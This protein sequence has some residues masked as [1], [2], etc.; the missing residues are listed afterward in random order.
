ML[1]SFYV[2]YRVLYVEWPAAGMRET[3]LTGLSRKASYLFARQLDGV[4]AGLETKT[5]T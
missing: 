3:S 4:L 5:S 2:S 1:L